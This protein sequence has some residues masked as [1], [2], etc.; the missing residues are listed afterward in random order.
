MWLCQAIAGN[1]SK[2]VFEGKNAVKIEDFDN[3]YG[4]VQCRITSSLKDYAAELDELIKVSEPLCH[5]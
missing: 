3:I 2:K 1:F 4:D 5:K